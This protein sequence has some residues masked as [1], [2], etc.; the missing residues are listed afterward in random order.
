MQI[1]HAPRRH[2]LKTIAMLGAYSAVGDRVLS[3]VA[4]AD[5]SAMA[6]TDGVVWLPISSFPALA[7]TNGSLRMRL[8]GTPTSVPTMIVTNLGGGQFGVV[9]ARCTHQGT[10]VDPR[11]AITGRLRCSNHGSEFTPTGAV[12]RGPNTGGTIQPLPSFV[13]AFDAGQNVLKITIPNMAYSIS[14]MEV[15]DTNGPRLR[16]SFPTLSGMRYEIRRKLTLESQWVATTFSTTPDG[17]ATVSSLTG[18]NRVQSVY[19]ERL[20]EV[21]FFT[22]LRIN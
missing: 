21:G 3:Q 8:P 12:L 6:V 17:A 20:S 4:L 9:D 22:L 1:D 19:V 14:G 13:S 11:N 18:N 7:N 10:L 2:F 15:L 16:L 5:I